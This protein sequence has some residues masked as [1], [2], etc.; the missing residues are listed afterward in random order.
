MPTQQEQ[1]TITIKG[2]TFIFVILFFLT[3]NININNNKV[4]C[5]SLN[6]FESSSQ[7]ILFLPLD[8]RYI[9]FES[10]LNMGTAIPQQILPPNVEW[11]P[12]HKQPANI[13]EI[14]NW[15]DSQLAQ[16][17][18]NAC[19]FSA[20]M[21]LYGGLISSRESNDTFLLIEKR[22]DKLSS[23]KLKYPQIKFYLST[24]VMRI[25][26][27]NSDFEEPWYWAYYGV[28][29]YNYSFY[30][31]KYWVLG[32]PDD[33]KTAQTWVAPVPSYIVSDWEWR[34][35]R[36]HNISCNLL[37]YQQQHYNKYNTKL[38]EHIFITLDDNAEYGFN[39]AEAN[40]LK[41]LTKQYKLDQQVS[42]YPGADE[43]SYVMLARLSSDIAK[44]QP[45]FY[46]VFRDPNATERIPNYE[47][48][49]VIDTI[50]QQI[51]AAGGKITSDDT[52]TD[53]YFLVNNFSEEKQLEAPNQ[54]TIGR[55]IN[56]FNCF[57]KYLTTSKVLAFADV[58]F[59][60]G[61]DLIFVDYINSLRE[62]NQIDMSYFAYA[63]WNTDG[64]T[65][66]LYL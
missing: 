5:K 23:L 24:V 41:N 36:N 2:I 10:V 25:P 30:T 28:N 8:E 64:N 43:V 38:F 48:Q 13:D 32:N 6:Q 27:Y 47:G 19:I 60:N 45:V 1:N 42:I 20:E 54:P 22:L 16:S 9:T 61:A 66:Y 12:K 7:Q 53:I 65:L 35:L 14:H 3:I 59:S 37:N 39:I 57:D 15:V 4:L 11:L 34:R 40:H 29:L 46:L 51:I 31:H 21:Y 58:R 33:Y 56:E 26:S 62:S 18:I 50:N 63:G 44:Y 17:S 55:S 49:P 52:N